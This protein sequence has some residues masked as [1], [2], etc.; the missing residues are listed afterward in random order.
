[1]S[2]TVPLLQT[3]EPDELLPAPATSG[4]INS[5]NA[6]KPAVVLT[7]TNRAAMASPGDAEA[8][9]HNRFDSEYLVSTLTSS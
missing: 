2:A 6:P 1:M 4:R 5:N 8:G 3:I 9:M 7:P